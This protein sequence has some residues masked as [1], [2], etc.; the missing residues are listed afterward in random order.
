[1][2]QFPV[3]G[4]PDNITLPVLVWQ[5]GWVIVPGT[6]CVGTEGGF[7]MVMPVDGR[8]IHPAVFVTVNV[9]VPAGSPV[10]V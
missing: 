6:G 10:T 2:V 3:P 5:S 1:M 9:K 7:V 8:D 4:R